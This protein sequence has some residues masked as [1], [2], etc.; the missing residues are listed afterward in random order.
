[1]KLLFE[2]WRKFLEEEE[3]NIATV[4]VEWVKSLPADMERPVSRWTKGRDTSG[5]PCCWCGLTE[6]VLISV[7]HIIPQSA[8]G[9]YGKARTMLKG[10]LWNLAWACHI[11]NK[12]RASDI[13]SVS[14]EWMSEHR[15][16]EP[17]GWLHREFLNSP[18][19][20]TRKE[21]VEHFRLED[22]YETP[23]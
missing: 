4:W 2:S 20:P 7:E 17:D 8:G 22:N 1:M 11:C 16:S 6:N 13:G 12:E 15:K 21:L 3:T 18:D 14:H 9:S 19:V 5:I 10:A 23:I